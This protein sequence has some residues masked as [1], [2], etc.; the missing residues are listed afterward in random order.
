MRSRD[1]VFPFFSGRLA[2]ASRSG[3]RETK[4]QEKRFCLLY[5]LVAQSLFHLIPN[6]GHQM[7]FASSSPIRYSSAPWIS[8]CAYDTTI[9]Q[10]Y[11]Y[12]KGK[13]YLF[14]SKLGKRQEP[15]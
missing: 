1:S 10:F 13:S 3:V 8:G 15:N 14:G 6:H 9:Y 12:L 11:N 2:S 5:F 7:G 4:K